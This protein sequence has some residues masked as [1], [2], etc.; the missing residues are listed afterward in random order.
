[1]NSSVGTEIDFGIGKEQFCE[2]ASMLL[3]VCQNARSQLGEVLSYLDSDLSS[4]CGIEM[5]NIVWGLRPDIGLGPYNRVDYVFKLLNRRIVVRRVPNLKRFPNIEGDALSIV[6]TMVAKYEWSVVKNWVINWEVIN[7]YG[8]SKFCLHPEDQ[9]NTAQQCPICNL[10]VPEELARNNVEG[11]L[12]SRIIKVDNTFSNIKP[13]HSDFECYG[14]CVWL[15]NHNEKSSIDQVRENKYSYYH[16][17]L[18]YGC[19]HYHTFSPDVLEFN[20][21]KETRYLS[22]LDLKFISPLV[23][24]IRALFIGRDSIGQILN[25]FDVPMPLSRTFQM[26]CESVKMLVRVYMYCVFYLT[27]PVNLKFASLLV[28]DVYDEC[29]RWGYENIYDL[30][31][32]EKYINMNMIPVTNATYTRLNECKSKHIYIPRFVVMIY[33]N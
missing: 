33:D 9:I 5:S 25:V 31:P 24:V 18:T 11:K 27:V 8:Y 26:A 30:I 4:S 14:E 29:I 1:M 3:D 19:L 22:M 21:L 6:A 2:R 13:F 12:C 32:F 23:R 17:Y 16:W 15:R 10:G 20:T 7:L 28:D